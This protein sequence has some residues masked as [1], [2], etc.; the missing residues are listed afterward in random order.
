MSPGDIV[1][2]SV[3]VSGNTGTVSI[4]NESTDKSIT[5]TV[6]TTS[7]SCLQSAQWTV[8]S[9]YPQYE[10][11][12]VDFGTITFNGALAVSTEAA[13]V[14]PGDPGATL[15]DIDI[16]GEIYTSTSLSGDS[17]MAVTYIAN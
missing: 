4:V 14:G 16:V 8:N 5:E 12:L 9:D 10:S 1:L 11:P 3:S 17:T 13:I 7:G 15:Y 6:T 2:L